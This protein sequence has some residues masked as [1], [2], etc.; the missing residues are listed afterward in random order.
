MK[1]NFKLY[2]LS[3][4]SLAVVATSCK[5]DFGSLNAPTVEDYQKDASPDQL[6]GLVIG[7]LSGMRLGEGTYLDAV[8]VMGREAYRFSNADP[9]F[10]TELLGQGTITLNNTGFYLTIPWTSHYRTV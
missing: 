2:T 5:K 8:A 6:N 7:T 9:R 4:L 10:V 3:L 1:R